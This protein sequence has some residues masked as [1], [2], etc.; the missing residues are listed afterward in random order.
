MPKPQKPYKGVAMEGVIATWY[1]KNTGRDL[2]RFRAGS[3]TVE[4][5]VAPGG[6]VLEVAPGPGY[7]AIELARLGRYQVAGLDISRSF[8]RIAR[9]NAFRAGVSIDFQHGD[10]AHMPFPEASFDFVISMAAF[11]NF[12]DPVGALDEVHRV[13]KPGGSASI[14]DLRRDA[15]A[16]AIDGEVQRMNLSRV[17]SALTRW[18]LRALLKRA[19]SRED[20]ARMA[21][22]SRFG[23]C[24][25][26]ADGIGFEL[27]LAKRG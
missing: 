23:A 19:Y 14:F 15:S 22:Q 20:L 6:R 17:S 24:E 9:E 8:V 7:L 11:K 18:T 5:R 12:S 16:G 3:R 21:A 10:A 13:L 27:R 26:G 2:R 25:I 1:T 4:E